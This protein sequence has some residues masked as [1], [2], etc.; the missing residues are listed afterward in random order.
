MS[1]AIDS[2][3]VFKLKSRTFSLA[4]LLFA[5]EDRRAIA[6]LYAF[7]R[8]LDDFA[9][10]TPSGERDQLD[11]ICSDI[12]DKPAGKLHPV[13]EDFLALAE[14]RELPVSVAGELATALRADCGPRKISS[15]PELL[16]FAYGVAGTV[17]LLVCPLL[18]VRDGR[19]QAFAVDLGIGL[20][21]TNIARDVAE[22]ASR[23]RFYLP[24]SWIRP[25]EL[26]RALAGCADAVVKLDQAVEKILV[27]AE[28]FYASAFQGMFFIPARNRRAIFIAA[29]L[30]RA[31]GRKLLKQGSG[32]WRER[33]ILGVADKTLALICAVPLYRQLKCEIWMRPEPPRHASQIEAQLNEA[34]IELPE[35]SLP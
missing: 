6:R 7:C 17:G 30:Y 24:S 23:E 19:A 5:A 28:D 18:Q 25:E 34:G 22:D 9:D 21:L 1:Q 3:A 35:Y 32:G 10:S 4:A 31:I 14:E 29:I 8:A 20:Q 27:L 12:L 2:E 26:R 16:R 33:I 13:A 11:R 15:Q